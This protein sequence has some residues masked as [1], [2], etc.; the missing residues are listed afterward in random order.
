[1]ISVYSVST[2][3]ELRELIDE[4][5]K[6][7][8]YAQDLNIE[9]NIW[10]SDYYKIEYDATTVGYACI[11]ASHT[12]WEF[13]L[14]ENAC[15]HAQEIFKYLIEMKYIVAAECKTYDNLLMSLCHDFQK[16][17]EGSAYL[18]RDYIGMENSGSGHGDIIYR[19][20]NMGDYDNLEELNQIAEEVDFFHDL[21]AE[22]K[23]QEVVIFLKG[24]QV[25]GAGT[26]KK[27]RKDS[28]YRDIGMVVAKG[29]RKKGIGTYILIKLKEYC[30]QHDLIP[31][32]GC[33]YYN[34]SSKKTLEKAG[35]ITKHRVIRFTF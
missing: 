11:D 15:I 32:C 10:D 13:Y 2:I 20:A 12:L 17:S 3:D 14:V 7:L 4:Y 33:W 16:G 27:I 6:R 5:E 22:I 9:E 26:F 34:Y 29:H 25:V 19:L 31:V 18:F 8:P 24:D 30:D 1:M 23:H 28:K 21:K 35:F